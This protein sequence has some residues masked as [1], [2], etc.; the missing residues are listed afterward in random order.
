M[1]LDAS[2]IADLNVALDGAR[3][4]DVTWNSAAHEVRTRLTVPTLA[5]AGLGAAPEC[6]LRLSSASTMSVLLRRDRMG[7]IDFGPAI[8]LEGEEPLRNFL[9]S[10]SFLNP[11][12]GRST[13]DD[14]SPTDD[15]PAQSSLAED[16]GGTPA[17]HS[18]YWSARCGR[19]ESGGT[20][21]YLLECLV[22][23]D[24]LLATVGRAPD[25]DLRGMA[26]RGR[27][28]WLEHQGEASGISAL[29][30]PTDD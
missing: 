7:V 13:L 15:W 12:P 20:V 18:W 26:R 11:L 23:F 5:D 14:D 29:M 1:A 21:V 9:S 28:W 19:D 27:K 24:V 10:L 30:K 6:E 25:I 4:V 8:P 2:L 16:L 17:T 22:R 3:L